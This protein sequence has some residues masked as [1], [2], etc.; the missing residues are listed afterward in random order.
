MRNGNV[1]VPPAPATLRC[2]LTLFAQLLPPDGLESWR[3]RS[4][5]TVGVHVAGMDQHIDRIAAAADMEASVPAFI[6]SRRK[7]CCGRGA[8]PEP[9]LVVPARVDAE[10]V[11]LAVEIVVGDRI[12]NPVTATPAGIGI[13][14][15]TSLRLLSETMKVS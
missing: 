13:A 14:Q 1:A 8:M 10:E 9:Y 4:A 3:T 15:R 7:R 11:R 2:T 5:L 12:L 6:E